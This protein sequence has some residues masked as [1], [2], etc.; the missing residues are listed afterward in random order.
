[1]G[2]L[3]VLSK[4][5]DDRLTWDEQKFQMN[6]PEAT[7]AVREAE[8]IFAETRARGATAFRVEPGKPTQRID[9][10]DPTAQQILIV[11][12]VVGG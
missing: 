5:G 3:R 6:D 12:R 8:R 4:R 10:F 9:Q 7:A 2:V 1:M 11:P